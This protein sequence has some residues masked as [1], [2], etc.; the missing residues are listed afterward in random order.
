LWRTR[1]Q[2]YRQVAELLASNFTQTVE[3]SPVLGAH[4]PAS[5]RRRSRIGSRPASQRS[6][7]S[8]LA[9]WLR[10]ADLQSFLSR[11]MLSE[12]DQLTKGDAIT[13]ARIERGVPVLPAWITDAAG[14]VLASFGKGI[15][16][17]RA[18]VAAAMTQSWSIEGRSKRW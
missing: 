17:D 11:L 9:E 18:A 2:Y 5:L 3:A 13:V 10:C 4:Q 14:S 6:S 12:R 8:R 1:Q 16:A 7:A 15:V